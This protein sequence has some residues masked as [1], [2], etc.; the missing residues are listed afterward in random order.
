M[1]NNGYSIIKYRGLVIGDS[2]YTQILAKKTTE[3]KVKKGFCLTPFIKFLWK[4]NKSS[5]LAGNK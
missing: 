2:Q 5:R 3:I 1:N 4:Q